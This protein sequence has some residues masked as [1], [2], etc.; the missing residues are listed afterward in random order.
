MMNKWKVII[1]DD[2]E[3]FCFLLSQLLEATGRFEVLYAHDG[4]QGRNLVIEKKPDLV[5]LDYVMPRVRGDEVVVSLRAD[6][7]TKDIPI[8]VTSG[9][10]EAVYMQKAFQK[11]QHVV[12]DGEGRLP[13]PQELDQDEERHLKGL[14]GAQGFLEKPFSRDVLFEIVRQVLNDP[15]IS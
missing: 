2:E 13:L 6:E 12:K 8:I 10:G 7:R 9:L 5:F 1:I 15:T 14:L 4:D 3:D 11:D